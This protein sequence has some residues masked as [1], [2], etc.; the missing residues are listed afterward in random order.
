MVVG[1]AVAFDAAEGFD[2]KEDDGLL[3]TLLSLGVIG[4]GPP[5]VASCGDGEVSADG[6]DAV[7]TLGLRTDVLAPETE[8]G[9]AGIGAVAEAVVVS[10]SRI[11]SNRSGWIVAGLSGMD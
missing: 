10:A 7:R 5:G 11:R 6:A 1:R 9:T 3:R 2:G 4:F 8:R